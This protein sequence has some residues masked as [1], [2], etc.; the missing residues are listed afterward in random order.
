MLLWKSDLHQKIEMKQHTRWPFI[1]STKGVNTNL[2]ISDAAINKQKPL[3]CG[4][5]Y[6]K[7]G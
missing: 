4:I 3:S 7:E 6:W 2:R 1:H 5:L